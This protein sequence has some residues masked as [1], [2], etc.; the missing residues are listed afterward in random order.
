MNEKFDSNMIEK[1]LSEIIKDKSHR[2]RSWDFCN[3]AFSVDQFTKDNA[4]Q[5][6]FYLASWGM[7]RGSSGLLQKNYLIHEGAVK[8]LF[9]EEYRFLKC[10]KI[11]DIKREKIDDILKL[12]DELSKH[13]RDISYI[14]G[15]KKSK[16]ISTTDTLISKIMLGTLACVPAYDKYFIIGL[17]ENG[18]KNS[19]FNTDSLIDLFDFIKNNEDWILECQQRIQKR[20]QSHYPLMKIIDMYFWQIGY[21][22]ALKKKNEKVK[23]ERLQR[24]T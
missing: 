11:Q 4:L 23:N 18:A 24:N 6:A 9:S 1:Y 7:Y 20:I 8:I 19:K 22:V 3:Q 14:R 13:Y 16:E 2:Y 15:S 17:K 5:L 12:K 21:D 10:N